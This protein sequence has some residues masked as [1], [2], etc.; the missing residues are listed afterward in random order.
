MYNKTQFKASEKAE[1]LLT[2]RGGCEIPDRTRQAAVIKAIY[3][4]APA[5][6]RIV[7]GHGTFYAVP[8]KKGIEWAQQ[9]TD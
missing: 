9:L 5:H 2:I 8:T 6:V 7:W 3:Y 4:S 1:T